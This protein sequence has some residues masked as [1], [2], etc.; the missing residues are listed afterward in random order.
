[1]IQKLKLAMFALDHAMQY[2]L[3]KAGADMCGG[4]LRRH[5]ADAHRNLS[6]RA[7]HHMLDRG[8]H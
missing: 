4:S 7:L 5:R 8:D 3:W 2:G 1:M 6:A